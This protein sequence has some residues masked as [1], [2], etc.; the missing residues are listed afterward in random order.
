MTSAIAFGEAVHQHQCNMYLARMD[1][2]GVDLVHHLRLTGW[3]GA[4]AMFRNVFSEREH[5]VGEID[6]LIVN[7]GRSACGVGLFAALQDAGADA[8]RVGDALGPRSFEEVVREGPPRVGLSGLGRPPSRPDA[9]NLCAHTRDAVSPTR[10][11]V[12]PHVGAVG[13]RAQATVDTPASA[14]CAGAA[15]GRYRRRARPADG[16]GRGRRRLASAGSTRLPRS[17]PNGATASV[18][19]TSAVAAI[20]PRT[21]GPSRAST[22]TACSATASPISILGVRGRSNPLTPYPHALRDSDRFKEDDDPANPPIFTAYLSRLDRKKVVPGTRYNASV[23]SAGS[24]C[25][26]N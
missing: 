23:G 16:G 6:T 4:G 3:D 9:A 5:G 22:S 19:S 20:P 24:N 8:V 26:A 17:W 12:M 10:H 7:D 18:R 14:C 13:E 2:A 21:V 15:A 25:G 1:E 11:T